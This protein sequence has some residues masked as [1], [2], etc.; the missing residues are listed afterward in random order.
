MGILS[1]S[2]SLA[3]ET[4]CKGRTGHNYIADVKANARA[5]KWQCRACTSKF[6]DFIRQQ[7]VGWST[8]R[9]E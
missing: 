2:P 7:S 5:G 9:P 8:I 4:C 3:T 1:P 6:S